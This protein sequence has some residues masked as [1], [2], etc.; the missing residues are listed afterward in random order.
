MSD[1]QININ[2]DNAAFE[3]EDLA[4]EIAACLRNL[5][6]RIEEQSR[7]YLAGNGS[8]MRVADSNGNTVGF[9]NFEIEEEG[10]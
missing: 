7:S 3:G 9:A 5:A 1:I 2:L 10:E 8:R 6:D 4:P